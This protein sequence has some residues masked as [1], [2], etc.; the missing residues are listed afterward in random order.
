MRLPGPV[1]SA[2]DAAASREA[3]TLPPL[4]DGPKGATR[5]LP[6]IIGAWRWLRQN[7]FSSFGNTLLTLAALAFLAVALPPFIRWA[8]LDASI[9]GA[10][11]S[12]CS[13]DGACWTFIKTR[14]P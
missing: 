7:L 13:G 12:V 9:S 14:L 4:A 11:R 2:P 5:P 1:F 3:P 8:V 6:I 10:A